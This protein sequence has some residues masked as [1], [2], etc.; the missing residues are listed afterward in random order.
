MAEKK[1]GYIL[2]QVLNGSAISNSLKC[3]L[4]PNRKPYFILAKRR[5]LVFFEITENGLNP[6]YK[7]PFTKIIVSLRMMTAKSLGRPNG[8]DMVVVF[9]HDYSYIVFSDPNHIKFKYTPP[10]SEY[11]PVYICECHKISPI[12]FTVNQSEQI[13]FWNPLDN[14]KTVYDIKCPDPTIIDLK[15]LPSHQQKIKFAILA[16]TNAGSRSVK[17]FI[18]NKK[19]LILEERDKLS[20][21]QLAD[22]TSSIIIPFDIIDNEKPAFL[23]LG[24]YS[25][26]AVYKT[27]V[28]NTD[29]PF[30]SSPTCFCKLASSYSA[31]IATVTGS[32]YGL[33]CDDQ[34]NIIEIGTLPI[35]PTSITKIDGNIFHF[36][37]SSG[38]SLF[39]QVTNTTIQI[40]QILDQFT[41][42]NSFSTYCETTGS[43]FLTQGDE[44]FSRIAELKTGMSFV[45]EVEIEIPGIE[46]IFCACGH[47]LIGSKHDNTSFIIDTKT[48]K[49]IEVDR[50]ISNC[51]TL[52]VIQRDEKSFFQVCL[53]T[54]RAVGANTNG[55]AISYDTDIYFSCTDNENI[56]LLFSE[57]AEIVTKDL[58][59]IDQII[60]QN[61]TAYTAAL[62]QG[63]IAVS[64][65]SGEIQL[66]EPNEDEKIQLQASIE[67]SDLI[68]SLQFVV[69]NKNTSLVAFAENGLILRYEINRENDGS[70]T[71]HQISRTQIGY[72]I[73]NVIELHSDNKNNDLNRV[74]FIN[75]S[76]P[77]LLYPDGT[78]VS[79]R[80][81]DHDASCSIFNSTMSIYRNRTIFIGEICQN[82]KCSITPRDCESRPLNFSIHKEPLSLF[83]SFE[84][85]GNFEVSG[86]LLPSFSQAYNLPMKQFEEVTDFY[87]HEHL[88]TTFIGSAKNNPQ[89][90]PLK[91]RIFAI[92]EQSNKFISILE[93]E[94]DE[95]VY[96]ITSS[97]SNNL[98]VGSTCKLM[99]LDISILS[100]GLLK[101]ETLQVLS[102]EVIPRSVSILGNY[103]FYFGA[104]KAI[105]VF[106]EQEDG[107]FSKYYDLLIKT[108]LH[109]GYASKQRGKFYRSLTIDNEKVLTISSITLNDDD[110]QGER[111]SFK[112]LSTFELESPVSCFRPVRDGYF[113][114][115]TRNGSFYALEEFDLN[116]IK[117]LKNVAS[118]I[119]KKLIFQ[120][121]DSKILDV[122]VLNLFYNLPID[123]QQEI[124]TT[125][126]KNLKDIEYLI[127][128][129]S[130]NISKM[131]SHHEIEGNC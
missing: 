63:L 118:E 76:S 128:L 28:T 50:F 91:G 27:A 13:A 7:V 39:A 6:L 18:F 95:N 41:P 26:T 5:E 51:K 46:S 73:K 66:F 75:C 12:M 82:E 54:I 42:V 29:A 88:Q 123:T 127:N 103:I 60:F 110:I 55:V 104:R 131:C 69:Y 111:V 80:C 34:L 96:T 85:N 22:S 81:D 24:T 31:L 67:V 30:Q 8:S 125:I 101:M 43:I 109:A 57:N 49:L 74:L 61:S 20:V 78:F 108:N 65:Y 117:V 126:G 53:Q 90:H 121:D 17:T 119:G 4:S 120:I 92:K 113:L 72:L 23:V 25:I 19:L 1:V 86:F 3:K 107:I 70:L 130:H 56:L 2:Q 38:N 15:F 47:Y 62:Y 79:I 77:M 58:E 99:I 64:F 35:S 102:T 59:P 83:V 16:D 98:I 116:V 52:N 129:V 122:S 87:Y 40:L 106:Q 114:I 36:G 44:H 45:K 89:M 11:V 100:D 48:Y 105:T 10:K 37:S 115:S 32:L 33:H 71:L 9:F 112:T 93:R 14:P 94:I 21:P 124:A 84:K 97:K 68:I